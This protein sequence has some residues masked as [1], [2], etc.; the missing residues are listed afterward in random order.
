M[1]PNFLVI[2]AMK[3]GT[4]SLYEYLRHHPQIFMSGVKEL[5]FF[6]EHMNWRRGRAWYEAQFRSVKS[7]AIAIGEAS[8]SYSKHPLL[9]GVPARVAAL[10]PDVRLIYLVRHPIERMR[11]HYLHQVII[12]KERRPLAQALVEM[13]GYL[14][15]SQYALQ[16]EQYLRYVALERILIV[17]SEDLRDARLDT[18]RQV[19]R[20]LGV[21]STYVPPTLTHEFLR[22][23]EHR[24][25]RRLAKVVRRIRSRHSMT[26]LVP[27]F[28]K[29]MFRRAATALPSTTAGALE[30]PPDL[31]AHLEDL[32]RN[33]VRR[34]RGYMRGHFDGWGIA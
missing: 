18:V 9:P 7:G 28:L 8:P 14:I 4:T 26:V 30:I 29:R 3:A 23:D 24:R 21:D 22:A 15:T 27:R 32:V 1:L 25:P 17:K 19:Y 31:R 12:G 11:S 13:P 34:L 6:V 16:V 33:D 20:F 2:G 5:D 10:L